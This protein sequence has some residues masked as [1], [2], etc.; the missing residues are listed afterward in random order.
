[1]IF[2]S[3]KKLFKYEYILYKIIFK[4]ENYGIEGRL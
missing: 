1:M 4:G 3:L 2:N